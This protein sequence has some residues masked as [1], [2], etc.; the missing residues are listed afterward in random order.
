M[1]EDVNAEDFRPFTCGISKFVRR[2]VGSAAA[3]ETGEHEV[4]K[5]QLG[6]PIPH[7]DWEGGKGVANGWDCVMNGDCSHL[8]G[9][10]ERGW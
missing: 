4:E 8:D 6:M 7:V 10:E 5:W 3:P 2:G 1:P 9:G